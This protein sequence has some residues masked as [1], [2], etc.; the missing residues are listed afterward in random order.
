MREVRLLQLQPALGAQARAARLV[1]ALLRGAVCLLGLRQPLVLVRGLA[2]R[3][4]HALL[5]A[6]GARGPHVQR[7]G[8]LR[9][10]LAPL[11]EL[12]APLGVL[13]FQPLA[14]FLGMAQLRLV[15]CDLRVRPVAVSYTHLTLPTN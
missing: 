11:R 9:A 6:A 10:L 12:R 8:E 1:Q 3:L 14:R 13:A 4:D 2:L 5:G 15:A 7:L